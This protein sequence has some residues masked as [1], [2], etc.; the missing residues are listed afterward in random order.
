MS[1]PPLL[2][3]HKESCQPTKSQSMQHFCFKGQMQF[4]EKL[5]N[6]GRSWFR[7]LLKRHILYPL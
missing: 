7:D 2:I 3:L 5:K 6:H 4:S 1:T